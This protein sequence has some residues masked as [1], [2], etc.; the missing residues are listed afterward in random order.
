MEKCKTL[1]GQSFFYFSINEEL[2]TLTIRTANNPANH[3]INF[4]DDPIAMVWA[5]INEAPNNT[6]QNQT[7]YYNQPQW[8]ECPNMILCP[9][10]AKL[11]LD[12]CPA[13]Q[14]QLMINH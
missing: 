13:E 7:Q 10:I 3:V 12:V 9:Y 4:G 14:I 2:R 6:L 8:P 1:G 11:L 5:R